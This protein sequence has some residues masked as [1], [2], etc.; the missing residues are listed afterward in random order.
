MALSGALNQR[1]L[2][3]LLQVF[4]L[5]MMQTRVSLAL[6]QSQTIYRALSF[7]GFAERERSRSVCVSAAA[8]SVTPSTSDPSHQDNAV[9]GDKV[10]RKAAARAKRQKLLI[11]LA[12]AV[13]RGDGKYSASYRPGGIDGKSFQA[14]SGLPDRTR[15]FTVLGIETSCDD[16]GAAIIRSDGTIL[17]EALAS[18]AKIH[19][20]WGGVV[21][22]L[23]RD[24]HVAKM[25]S[26][27]QQALQSA[28]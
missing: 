10:Q 22:G 11:G 21:P 2:F 18:Q 26:V 23:A 4:L 27:I 8:D 25:D 17:G 16:T 15:P 9:S 19:E 7:P 28:K 3:F 24:A 1:P 13:D 20:A 12:K 6:R 5:S 14:L